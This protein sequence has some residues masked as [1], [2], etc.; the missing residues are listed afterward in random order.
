MKLRK[1]ILKKNFWL[2]EDVKPEKH[3]SHSLA[4]FYTDNYKNILLK[5]YLF[6]FLLISS[7]LSYSQQWEWA[8]QATKTK[9]AQSGKNI[10]V[11]YTGNV[12]ITGV[13]YDSAYFNAT[14]LPA[15][16]FVAKYSPSGAFLWAK[17]LSGSIKDITTDALGNIYV[18]GDFNGTINIGSYTLVSNGLTDLY[19]ATLNSSGSVLSAKSYGGSQQDGVVAIAIDHANNLYFTGSFQ[20]SITFDT[21]Q[22]KLQETNTYLNGHLLF[23]IVKLDLTHTTT[24][25]RTC[26]YNNANNA[27]QY[28]S[29]SFICVDKYD[30]IYVNGGFHNFPCNAPIY[31]D[32]FF[33]LKYNSAGIL[34]LNS[35]S[36]DAFS[37]P[38]GLAVDDSLNIL[39]EYHSGGMHSSAMSLCK[40]DSL[41]STT[42]WCKF[43]GAFQ[44]GT[45]YTF[46]RGLSVD[47]LG[48]AYITGR[49]GGAGNP[50]K[51]D[52][53]QICNQLII[54]QGG[55]DILIGKFSPAGN[56]VWVQ[57]AGG[58]GNDNLYPEGNLRVD[59]SGNCYLVGNYNVNIQPFNGT[60]NDTVCFITDT[61][62]NDGNWQQ[63]YLAKINSNNPVTNIP[64]SNFEDN[65]SLVFPNPTSKNITVSFLH[66]NVSNKIILY[67][68][69]GCSLQ[70]HQTFDQKIQLDLS[71]YEK[72]VYFL[73]TE[74]K[75]GRMVKKIILN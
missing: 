28:E 72:G 32:G 44:Y 6:L 15:G 39:V 23:Y 35:R 41:M 68:V 9:G 22:L 73:E 13:N 26:P 16:N 30:N 55:T 58:K 64:K 54:G 66:S 17:P 52:S 37:Y 59:R 71:Q 10:A 2:L 4:H 25:A 33:I 70:S 47:S 67:N 21:I 63:I 56:C 36:W 8:K 34:K 14:G 29:P 65:E 62:S 46:D 11:D 53:V 12:L 31:C 27:Y 18:A 45:N 57:T 43:L 40:Y 3:F 42:K 38:V 1:S 19:I 7:F 49:F 75:Y 50:A 51:A 74:N 20:D 48:N 69:L 5:N 60:S 24:W 61:L